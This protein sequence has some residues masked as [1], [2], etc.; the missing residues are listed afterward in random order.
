M[1]EGLQLTSIVS[2]GRREEE[3]EA[4]RGLERLPDLREEDSSRWLCLPW[5]SRAAFLHGWLT[6]T[7]IL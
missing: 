6:T 4:R 7:S 2:E 1:A 5:V 3:R